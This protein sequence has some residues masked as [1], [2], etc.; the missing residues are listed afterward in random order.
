MRGL[1][2]RFRRAFSAVD[3]IPYLTRHGL[4]RGRLSNVWKFLDGIKLVFGY[5]DKQS[6]LMPDCFSSLL[7]WCSS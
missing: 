1:L 6:K 3:E 5:A 7:S 2:R 4:S